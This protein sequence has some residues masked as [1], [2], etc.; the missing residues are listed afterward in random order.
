[1]YTC[2]GVE[3]SV[4]PEEVSNLKSLLIRSFREYF[5]AS[6]VGCIRTHYPALPVEFS[7]RYNSIDRVMY[8]FEGTY[9]FLHKEMS[10]VWT[11]DGVAFRQ[12]FADLIKFTPDME[13][14]GYLP[15][16]PGS[17]SH[18][19]QN[20]FRDIAGLVATT[21]RI[22]RAGTYLINYMVKHAETDKSLVLAAVP[23]RAYPIIDILEN[24]FKVFP[25]ACTVH[26]EMMESLLPEQVIIQSDVLVSELNRYR[27]LCVRDRSE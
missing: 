23:A 2:Y 8:I 7:L 3:L 25:E 10:K 15:V 6:T 17:A 26:Q 4:S 22:I 19:V 1:M 18:N 24:T 11:L 5:T 16:Y 27:I 12:D 9:Y 21:A 14:E 20:A 13:P